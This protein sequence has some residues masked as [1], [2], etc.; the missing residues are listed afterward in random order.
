VSVSI[1]NIVIDTNDLARAATF[2]QSVTGYEITSSSADDTSLADPGKG[3]PGLSLQVVPEPRAGKNR[4]HLDLYTDDLDGEVTRIR[5]LGAAEVQRF[6][7]GGWIV[8]ADPD[9]NQFCVV[10]E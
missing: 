10:R 5:S 1:G 9:G 6:D 4:V 8:L 2:W 7:D 3:G